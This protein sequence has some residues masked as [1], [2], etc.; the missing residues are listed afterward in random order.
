MQS[1]NQSSFYG[2]GIEESNTLEGTGSKSYYTAPSHPQKERTSG[3]K[4]SHND[5]ALKN[6]GKKHVKTGSIDDLRA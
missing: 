6:S 1:K 5:T 2:T 4:S 3:G